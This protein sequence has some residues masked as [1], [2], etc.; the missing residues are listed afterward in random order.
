[1]SE[2]I[3]HVED[4]SSVD[5]RGTLRGPWRAIG[6]RLIGAGDTERLI[7]DGSEH[8]VYVWSGSGTAGT[9]E[10]S[11]PVNAGSAFTIVKG[12][13]VTFEA[14]PEGLRLFVATFD[15]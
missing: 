9:S 12:D 2:S 6:V 10:G 15:A 8:A 5:P 4:G 7:A 3:V 14:G 13:A 1:V 11:V